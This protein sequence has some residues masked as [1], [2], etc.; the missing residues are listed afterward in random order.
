MRGDN[1]GAVVELR[2]LSSMII[3]DAVA[4]SGQD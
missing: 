3:A 4:P 1:K 2:G